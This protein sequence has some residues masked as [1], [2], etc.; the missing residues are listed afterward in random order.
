M[1][2]KGEELRGSDSFRFTRSTLVGI[3]F[4][5]S[6]SFTWENHE[7]DANNQLLLTFKSVSP[8]QNKN[9][10]QQIHPHWVFRGVGGDIY[11]DHDPHGAKKII[12]VNECEANKVYSFKWSFS[13]K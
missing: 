11:T 2:P 13:Q 5:V 9:Y 3:R 12:L 6:P 8:K 1:G 10:T 7:A 4:I